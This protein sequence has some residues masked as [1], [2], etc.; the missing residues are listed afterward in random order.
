MS[1]KNLSQFLAE[2]DRADMPEAERELDEALEAGC[3][4]MEDVTKKWA[5]YEPDDIQLTEEQRQQLNEA[6]LSIPFIIG[7]VMAAPSVIKIIVKAVG[8][9]IKK[10]KKLFGK[11]E[12]PSEAVEKLIEFTEKWHKAYI[13]VIKKA[14][15]FGG[16]FKSAGIES[17]KNQ[18][19]AAEA[20]FYTI[21]FGF[22]VYS[23]LASGKIIINS[24]QEAS[25]KNIEMGIVEGVM[26]AIKS[27]EIKEFLQSVSKGA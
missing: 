5:C 11:S 4:Y 9:I 24:M 1:T 14:L 16:V 17:E 8:W 7:I 13:K 25:L 10:V 12:E 3:T 18:E 27:G 6:G 26:T 15:E 19:M 23:G 20:V 2:A 22:A 21:V